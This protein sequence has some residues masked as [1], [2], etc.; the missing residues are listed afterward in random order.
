MMAYKSWSRAGLYLATG[1]AVA[2]IATPSV[3]QSRSFNVPAQSISSA[4]STLGRQ[5]GI[6]I[7]L[8]GRAAKGVRANAVSG[9]MSVDEALDMMLRGTGLSARRTSAQTYT[10]VKTDLTTGDMVSPIRG[11]PARYASL[12]PAA[13]SDEVVGAS[14]QPRFD[15]PPAVTLNP[16]EAE[17]DK[18]IVVTAQKREERLKDVPVS[19][20]VL[21]GR[22]LDRST[23]DGIN[24]VLRTVPG[25][26]ATDAL[27]G[28]N[29]QLS[30][31]GVT[32][33]MPTL[34]MSSPIAFYLDGLP[35][36]FVRNAV[37]PD[38]D[39]YDLER[40]EVLRGPQ[41]TLY[42]ASALN[43]VVRVLTRD[44]DLNDFAGKVRG[45]VSSTEHGGFNYRGDVSVNVP[46]VEGKLAVRASA[47]YQDFSGWI[48][49]PN[50]RNSNDSQTQTYRVKV[51][52]QPTERLSIGVSGWFSRLD[53]GG[54]SY[55]TEERKSPVLVREPIESDYDLYGLKVDYDFD[56]FVATSNTAYL[57]YRNI[58]YGSVAN[59]PFVQQTLFTV[60]TFNQEVNLASTSQGPWKWTVGGMYRQSDELQYAAIPGLFSR[61]SRTTFD[62]ES[63][64]IFGEL[65][66]R[67]FDGKLELTGGMR[68]FK[69]RLRSDELETPLAL[70]AAGLYGNDKSSKFTPRFVL[71]WHPD[72]D[73]TVYGSYSEGFRSG[74]AATPAIRLVNPSAQ[75]ARPDTLKNYEIGS[76]GSLFGGLLSYDAAVYYIDWQ[77]IQLSLLTR[78][79][80]IYVLDI[81]NSESASG[82]GAELGVTMRPARGLTLSAN[83]AFNDLTIDKDVLSGP[84]GVVLFAKGSRLNQSPKYTAGGSATY[85]TALGGGY[86]GRL[87]GSLNYVSRQHM[88]VLLSNALFVSPGDPLLTAGLSASL[89]SPGRWHLTAFV[90]NITNENGSSLKNFFG[91]PYR[92]QRMRPRTI[93]VQME[94][95]F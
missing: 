25:V 32:G 68:Y 61:P 47:G 94:Y 75:A 40:V 67:F 91:N 22:E 78:L 89:Q 3:A 30:I 13:Q 34:A 27:Q 10:I 42:G 65:T 48:D 39:V 29:T 37:V 6:Q 26:A 79:Q 19:L 49:K 17:I 55:G 85:E 18:E 4:V 84:N 7:L 15:G 70:Q 83:A 14:S 86:R 63:S 12:K 62:S 52:A 50:D 43:G 38:A 87:S 35:F 20:T 73:V 69:D 60:R 74:A 59:T 21:D 23:A 16:A 88:K 5:A 93:G 44:A 11:Q 54:A 95:R 92:D 8:P 58:S 1:C 9:K 45:I 24:D 56:S 80:Q 64:A 33:A 2:A 41:G 57:K 76:K 28:G 46:I 71:N 66:R 81:I 82:L 51:N 36:S 31:R 53:F 72:K 90:D 77:D